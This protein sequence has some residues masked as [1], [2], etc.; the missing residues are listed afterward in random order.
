MM[1]DVIFISYD[2]PNADENWNKLVSVF[3]NAKRVH[4][5]NG[6][7]NAHKKAAEISN[8]QLFYVIDGDA[9]I[10]PNFDFSY[11]P[12]VGIRNLTHVWRSKNPVND[13]DYG[14]GGVKILSK[15]F[16]KIQ[17]NNKTLIDVTSNISDGLYIHNDIASITNFN[18]SPF[19]AWRGAFRECVKLASKSINGQI[20]HETEHRLNIWCTVGNDKKFGQFVID[21]ANAGKKYGLENKNEKEKLM[22]I[23][24]FDWLKKQFYE[25]YNN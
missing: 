8:T 1:M 11:K 6:I 10:L 12:P 14:Y 20:D 23:N 9:E 25:Y 15:N 16:F 5:I 13:L 18:S 2:E 19:H 24:N 22:L 7:F 3:Q 17:N 4:G 21:G